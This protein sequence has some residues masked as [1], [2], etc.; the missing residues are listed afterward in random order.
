MKNNRKIIVIELLNFFIHRSRII[1]SSYGLDNRSF[2]TFTKKILR[3]WSIHKFDIKKINFLDN[4]SAGNFF[5]NDKIFLFGNTNGVILYLN[6][7]NNYYKK[8]CYAHN[9]KIHNVIILLKNNLIFSY[10]INKNLKIWKSVFL[11]KYNDFLITLTLFKSLIFNTEPI[12]LLINDK[13]KYL[14]ISFIDHSLKLYLLPSIKY[15]FSFDTSNE[16]IITSNFSSNNNYLLGGSL[17]GFMFIWKTNSTTILHLRKGHAGPVQQL[18]YFKNDEIII[19]LGLEKFIMIW[20]KNFRLNLKKFQ[21]LQKN[22]F[23]LL[24]N[25]K[26]DFIVSVASDNS[27]KKFKILIINTTNNIRFVTMSNIKKNKNVLFEKNLIKIISTLISQ[28]SINNNTSLEY[29]FYQYCKY[30]LKFFNLN[31]FKIII[32]NAYRKTKKFILKILLKL[33]ITYKNINL[34]L[35]FLTVLINNSIKLH[36]AN[37]ECFLLLSKIHFI[38]LIYIN[39]IKELII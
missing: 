24:I 17:N 35:N 22:L 21:I 30:S 29:I 38:C 26:Y 28:K 23:V 4:I 3:L 25:T 16:V 39:N 13:E 2:F 34:S 5:L 31:F 12:E 9:N 11:K 15:R 6:T 19:S 7:K 10:S 18:K 36:L 37:M 14:L 1:F 33:I 32:T 8:I 20:N 27:L